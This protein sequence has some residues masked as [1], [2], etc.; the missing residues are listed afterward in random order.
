MFSRSPV[1][2]YE[3]KGTNKRCD[4]NQLAQRRKWELK[5]VP[6]FPLQTLIVDA[7]QATMSCNVI[8][9]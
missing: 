4:F 6:E 9:C 1:T 2:T 3:Q 8:L 5:D 7:V